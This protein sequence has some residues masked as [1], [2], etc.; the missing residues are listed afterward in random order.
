LKRALL[1]GIPLLLVVG[2]VLGLATIGI[3]KIPGISPR[4]YGRPMIAS[5]SPA[6]GFLWTFVHPFQSLTDQADAAKRKLASAPPP[7]DTSSIVKPD[8]SLGV[9]KLANLWNGMDV[10]KL[11]DITAKWDKATLCRVLLKMDP[12]QVTAYLAAV[13]PKRADQLSREIQVLAS[14][15]APPPTE[16]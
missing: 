14:V 10:E 12:D 9:A 3:L 1:I 15:P 2:I 13:D 7:P 11:A 5:P 16:S 4:N 6:P 8:P